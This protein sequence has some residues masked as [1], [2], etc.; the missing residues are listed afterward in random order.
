MNCNYFCDCDDDD[1]NGGGDD[2]DEGLLRGLVK[3]CQN[4]V[5]NGSIPM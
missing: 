4:T 2:D 1:D 5:H 3:K